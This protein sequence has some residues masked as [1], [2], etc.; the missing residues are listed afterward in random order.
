MDCEY[1]KRRLDID[2]ESTNLVLRIVTIVV[3]ILVLGGPLPAFFKL[4]KPLGT[5]ASDSLPDSPDVVE[6]SVVEDEV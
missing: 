3:D 6:Q 5:I 4:H 2:L 1:R